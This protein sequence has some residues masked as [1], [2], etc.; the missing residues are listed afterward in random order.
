[1]FV[2]VDD[3]QI[4]AAV[5]IFLAD[6]S[7]VGDGS[8]RA[9]RRSGHEQSQFVVT[10]RQIVRAI[11]HDGPVPTGL[12]SRPTMTFSELDRSPIMRLSGGGD[13]PTGK[14]FWGKVYKIF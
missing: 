5:E 10:R 8:R 3:L 2:N 7:H 9:R 1:M 6:L 14:K 11:C 12:R 4:V 13:H